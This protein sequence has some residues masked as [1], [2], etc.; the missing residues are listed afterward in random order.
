[1]Q[2]NK[3]MLYVSWMKSWKQTEK[4]G[5]RQQ[6]AAVFLQGPHESEEGHTRDDDTAG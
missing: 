1:M 6:E 4:S 3:F 2:F 5:H